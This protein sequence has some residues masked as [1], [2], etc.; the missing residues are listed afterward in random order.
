MTKIGDAQKT[1][2]KWYIGVWSTFGEMKFI[3]NIGKYREKQ[4]YT[5]LQL[6]EKYKATLSKRVRW[7]LLDKEKILE[8]VNNLINDLTKTRKRK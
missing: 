1:N 4:K 8:H 7:D 2:R 3:E 6:L 5:K